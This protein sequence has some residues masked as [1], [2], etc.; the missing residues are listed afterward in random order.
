MHRSEPKRGQQAQQHH[1]EGEVLVLQQ[2]GQK[3]APHHRAGGGG[4]L[5]DKG[6]GRKSGAWHWD[7]DSWGNRHLNTAGRHRTAPRHGR[8]HV[9][10][11]GQC[12]VDRIRRQRLAKVIAR[13]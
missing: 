1:A 3:I 7:N 6:L 12:Q 13:L 2:A 4:L 9:L 5:L 11:R 8:F 10:R